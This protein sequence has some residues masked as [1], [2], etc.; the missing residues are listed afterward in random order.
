MTPAILAS[1]IMVVAAAIPLFVLGYLIKYRKRV[2]LI[3]GYDPA[4]VRDHDGLARWMG[5]WAIALGAVTLAFAALLATLPDA[6]GPVA[7]G[8]ISVAVVSGIVMLVGCR[9]YTMR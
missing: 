6:V 4:R 2:N 5:S 3:A 7:A 1:L 9:R 8:F